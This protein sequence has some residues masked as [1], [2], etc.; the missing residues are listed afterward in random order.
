VPVAQA[1][2]VPSV[3]VPETQDPPAKIWAQAPE[4][5]L[6]QMPIGTSC[7]AMMEKGPDVPPPHVS[8]RIK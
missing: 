3:V 8:I 6:Q 1:V 7:A 5:L 4:V 2:P